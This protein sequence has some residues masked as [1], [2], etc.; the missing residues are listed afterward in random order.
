MLVKIKL[1]T[2]NLYESIKDKIEEEV[3]DMAETDTQ[4]DKVLVLT[5][6]T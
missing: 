2:L 5:G 1:V 6:P 4:L 3:V